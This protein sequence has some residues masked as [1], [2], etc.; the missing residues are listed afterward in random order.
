MVVDKDGPR[1]IRYDMLRPIPSDK[2]GPHYELIPQDGLSQSLALV[3][4][5][6]QVQND[7]PNAKIY[8]NQPRDDKIEPLYGT[9]SK[10][11]GELP[12]IELF[13][14]QIDR[15]ALALQKYAT[16]KNDEAQLDLARTLLI[17]SYDDLMQSITP[18]RQ[19]QNILQI[20]NKELLK[21]I[22]KVKSI[23]HKK[24]QKQAN[25]KVFVS[26]KDLISKNG[27]KSP[28]FEFLRVQRDLFENKN[29]LH[30]R[31]YYSLPII[32]LPTNAQSGQSLPQYYMLQQ[33]E[34][35][36]PTVRNI[37]MPTH[38]NLPAREFPLE[39]P[40][41]RP[42]VS[43]NIK[44][45]PRID[46]IGAKTK[47]PMPNKRT[48]RKDLINDKL[49]TIDDNL[50]ITEHNMPFESNSV[51]IPRHNLLN[52]IN[53]GAQSSSKYDKIV[54]EFDEFSW[55]NKSIRFAFD[56]IMPQ[57]TT[58]HVLP[59]IS[60]DITQSDYRAQQGRDYAGKSSNPKKILK[61]TIPHQNVL[62]SQNSDSKSVR[63]ESQIPQLALAD[64]I[65]DNDT[66]ED[67]ITNDRPLENQIHYGANKKANKKNLKETQSYGRHGEQPQINDDSKLCRLKGG[68]L[69]CDVPMEPLFLKEPNA[70]FPKHQMNEEKERKST[71]RLKSTTKQRSY[72]ETHSVKVKK[73]KVW[74]KEDIPDKYQVFDAK[75]KKIKVFKNN[76]NKQGIVKVVKKTVMRIPDDKLDDKTEQ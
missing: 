52:K 20:Y 27:R 21:Q 62:H 69:I 50:K 75:S 23:K 3:P 11:K 57:R 51:L 24:I 31:N 45:L 73:V 37:L 29:P 71:T 65:H 12:R 14:D 44:S 66:V 15:E 40:K 72:T 35:I 58:H 33:T 19:D 26:T 56:N 39:L 74:D 7:L 9:L 55:P 18:K 32:E 46:L 10:T 30:H 63:N 67:F 13:H 16:N 17:K 43:E 76:F 64:V 22:A 47:S 42:T 5:L 4:I 59:H 41:I 49:I 53:H 48:L 1:E 28:G 2:D 25:K 36:M 54:Q 6:E 70:L 61:E 60:L 38:E 68:K 34:E 8:W